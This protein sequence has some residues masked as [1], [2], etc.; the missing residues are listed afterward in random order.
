MFYHPSAKVFD[1][2]SA[3]AIEPMSHPANV[4]ATDVHSTEIAAGESKSYGYEIRSR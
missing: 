3:L 4:L 2:V 1:Q